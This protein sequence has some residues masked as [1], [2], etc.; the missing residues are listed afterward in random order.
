MEEDICISHAMAHRLSGPAPL[1]L[2]LLRVGI[3][4]VHV[5]DHN[6]PVQ[7]VDTWQRITMQKNHATV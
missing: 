6:S 3:P 7:L 4:Q 1:Q 2:D 5:H